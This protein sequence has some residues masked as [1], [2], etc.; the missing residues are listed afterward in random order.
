MTK[1]LH[2]LVHDS[3]QKLPN[4]P[5]II[6]GDDSISYKQLSNYINDI[7][8]SFLNLGLEKQ[9]R[10]A[11][12][13]PKSIDNVS[14]MFACT[15][16]GGA[17]VPINPLLK[18][19]QVS[20]IL[21]DCNVR[22]LITNKSRLNTIQNELEKCIDLIVVIVLDC[23]ASEIP[24][25][26]NK[27]VICWSDFINLKQPMNNPR[28]IDT[29]IAAILYTSGSTGKPKGVV[30]SHINMVTGAASVSEY[31]NNT[32]TDRI[33]ATLPF[34]FDYGFSQL[35]TAFL[36]GACVVLLDYLLPK[37]VLNTIEKYSITG[38]AGV[39]SLWI[40]LAKLKWSSKATESLRYVTNSGGAMPE[41][42]L[43]KLIEISPSTKIYL[44][45]GLT[46]AFRSTYLPPDQVKT[47]PT[48]IGK[49]IPNAHISV[50]R[51]DGTPCEPNEAGELVHQGSL[52]SLGYWN[53]SEK[54]AIRFKPAPYKEP[55]LV[56]EELAVW[57]GDTVKMDE[58][59][60]LYFVGRKDEM[61]KTSGY[62]ISPTEV[63][64]I[65]Y[66]TDLVSEA[67]AV[68]APHPALGQAVVIAATPKNSD[69]TQENEILNICKQ[70]MPNFMVPT[71][72]VWY[73]ELPRNPNG[74]FDRKKIAADLMKIYTDVK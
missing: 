44:M 53:D 67:C 33:L 59:G 41:A 54:T 7:A 47:R 20:H 32:H 21:N 22:I 28:I 23:N 6:H 50:V 18:A 27:R 60:Y 58:E 15:H 34:S 30:L 1:L 17:F 5:A 12:Y 64:E 31:L 48:S 8:L 39:P 9:D 42:T 10:I 38:L 37:D 36:S 65:V 19:P 11:L 70:N 73:E 29:D 71:K 3:S 63:E 26:P 13:L 45:Y 61:I 52:V 69:L 2:Q 68:G 24:K 46:E 72:I 4:S 62:R 49:A 35:S 14:S 25:I 66:S 56:L 40:Q 74:K 57:S 51:E 55:G 43:N 16:A